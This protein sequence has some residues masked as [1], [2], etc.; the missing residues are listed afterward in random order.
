MK[1]KKNILCYLSY[2]FVI[3]LLCILLM[4][5]FSLLNSG[6]FQFILYGVEGASPFLAVMLVTIQRNGLSGFKKY[7][8]QKYICNFHLKYVIRAIL[9]PITIL[10]MAKLTTYLMGY[11][12]TFLSIPS[13]KKIV[14][15]LWALFAEEL[16][17][18]GYLQDKLEWISSEWLIPFITGMIWLL[19]HYHFYLLGTMDS[20]IL[21]F[22]YGCI[23]ESYGY[24]AITKMAKGNI[25]PASVWHFVGNLFFNLYLFDSNWN[26]GSLIPFIV[27]N[28]YYTINIGVFIFYKKRYKRYVE[29]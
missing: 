24:Y 11:N 5:N 14:I 8:R 1:E 2:V 29:V 22:G 27:A 4:K 10:T 18:R 17:W 7:I 26:N 21:I 12:T 23:V 19:W 25:I 3:P 13:T 20:S 28:L 6:V 16:G 9:I 15:I